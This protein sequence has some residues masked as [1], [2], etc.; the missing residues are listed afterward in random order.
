MKW[1]MSSGSGAASRRR[2]YATSL[3]RVSAG[4]LLF[5]RGV[6]QTS[7]D[8]AAGHVDLVNARFTGT[9]PDVRI[10]GGTVTVIYPLWPFN[11]RATSS[12]IGLNP[13]IPWSLRADDGVAHVKADLRQLDVQAI[14]FAAGVSDVSLRLPVPLAVIPVEIAGGAHRVRIHLPAGV[15]A[16][17]EVA[18]GAADVDFDGQG[19]GAVGGRLRLE[20]RAASDSDTGYRIRCGAGVSKLTVAS[21][22]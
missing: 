9:I 15:A 2:D 3:G 19:F 18:K 4:T 1:Q 22:D 10:R 5:A 21:G 11:R 7:I 20:N 14:R 12:R 8:A 17:L 13:T 6:A 16:R